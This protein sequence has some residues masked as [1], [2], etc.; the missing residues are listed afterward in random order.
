MWMSFR[1]MWSITRLLA[2][3][4]YSLMGWKCTQVVTLGQKWWLQVLMGRWLRH[5]LMVGAAVSRK[6]WCA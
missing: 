6:A 5:Q 3:F 2:L 1:L 4:S